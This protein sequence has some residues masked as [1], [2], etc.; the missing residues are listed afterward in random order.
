[1]KIGVVG[2]GGVGKTTVSALLARAFHGRGARVLAIDTDSNP[3][4]G[5]SLGLR[6]EEIDA[7]PELPRTAVTG[8]R[9]LD[10]ES[11]AA[12]RDYGR[13]TPSG[14]TLLTAM[15]VSGAGAG[16]TCGGHRTV[17]TLLGEVIDEHADVTIVDME[18]GLEHLS[19]SG[20]TL[21]H[22][23]V[24]LV[25]TEPSRK[26]VVTASRTAALALELGIPRTYVVGNKARSDADEDFLREATNDA[27][28]ELVDVLPYVAE[29]AQADRDGG[30]VG[31]VPGAMS[32][33]LDRII[34]MLEEPATTLA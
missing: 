14:V 9:E 16:C 19:R 21:A 23:D 32:A 31:T 18:A 3:N 17:R 1:M 12:L 28:L 5:M 30:T 29:V 27:G 20:G 8:E 6:L 33:V 22:A 11:E 4:L 2:K 24:L 15:R 7:I 13:M 10:L 26:S 25:V 34:E